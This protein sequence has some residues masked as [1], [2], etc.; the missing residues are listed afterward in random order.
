MTCLNCGS[1]QFLIEGRTGA[2][3]VAGFVHLYQDTHCLR[4]GITYRE[5]VQPKAGSERSEPK[6]YRI[7]F[8]EPNPKSAQGKAE[9]RANDRELYVGWITVIESIQREINDQFSKRYSNHAQHW[10][11]CFSV[12]LSYLRSALDDRIQRIDDWFKKAA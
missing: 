3:S 10:L 4:C 9:L 7:Q 1:D 2:K 12:V 11:Y 5:D 6:R 8:Q